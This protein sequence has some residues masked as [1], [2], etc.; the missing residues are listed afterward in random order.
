MDTVRNASE[1]MLEARKGQV[2][3]DLEAWGPRLASFLEQQP[4][5]SGRV[6]IRDLE[7]PATRTAG[8]NARFVA[9]LDLGDGPVIRRYV[10]RYHP[11]KS[12]FH[13]YDIPAM[14][15][16]HK[17]LQWTGV[18]IATALWLDATG[19]FLGVPAFIMEHVEG[20]VPSQAYL[21]QGPIAEGSPAERRAMVSNV[22]QTLA[23]I[24]TVD[25]KGRG[26]AFLQERG[27][28]RTLLERD[29]SWY[30]DFLKSSLPDRVDEFRPIWDWLVENQPTLEKPVLNH[31]DCQLA[32]YMFR[33]V[34]VAAVLDWEMCCLASREADLAY[35]CVANEY[36]SAGLGALP[37]GFPEP[38]EWLA[39]YE[40]VSGY[41]IRNWE[42]YYT[43]M[44]YRL[45]MI[46]ICGSARVC[47]QDILEA[48]RPIWGWF[49]DRLIARMKELTGQGDKS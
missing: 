27:R 42:Y 11:P 14:Y 18:P 4:E 49:E 31:G 26:L 39:E 9:E 29:M 12:V 38:E 30:W 46:M 32:N 45:S 3:M 43:M 41:T 13:E 20:T 8:G 24:H 23:T 47:R 6:L 28:G 2:M 35:M 17:A 19:K 10:V 5:I 40:N 7:R 1:W 34:E 44:L 15:K 21:T 37:D 25:W 48:T 22:I 33:G 16:T 36:T